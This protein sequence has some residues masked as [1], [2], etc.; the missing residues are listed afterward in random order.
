MNFALAKANTTAGIDRGHGVVDAP[1][2]FQDR[3][4]RKLLVKHTLKAIRV[5][6]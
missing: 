2:L 3:S 1:P 5:H 6:M 4:E